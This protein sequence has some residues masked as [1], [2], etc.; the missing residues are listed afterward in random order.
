MSEK[1]NRHHPQFTD[2]Q[3]DGRMR[4]YSH[5][6]EAQDLRWYVKSLS[7]ANRTSLDIARKQK[8]ITVEPKIKRTIYQLPWYNLRS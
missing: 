1:N 2:C 8:A 7:A 3:N 5:Y 6:S 4:I